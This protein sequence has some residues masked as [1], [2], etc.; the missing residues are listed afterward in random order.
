MLPRHFIFAVIGTALLT[1]AGMAPANAATPAGRAI[2]ADRVASP[3][4]GAITVDAA[5]GK[6]LFED[7]ADEQGYPASVQKVM[8]LVVILDKVSQG[9]LK[10]NESVPIT[11]EASKTGGSQV[12]LD[13]REMFP[14]DELLYALMVQSANDAA[15][16]LATHVAGSKDA[17]IELMN[18]K[19]KAIGM[20][21]T[22]FHSV[23]GLPPSAGHEPDV[24]TARDL[25]LLGRE[26]ILKHPE[27]LKYTSTRKREFREGKFIMQNHDHLLATFTGCDGLKT[28]YFTQAGYSILA[29]ASRNNARVI[30]VV[31]GAA[32]GTNAHHP[33]AA[34]DAKAAELMNKGFA[35]LAAQPAAK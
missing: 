7:H 11:V 23:H 29:T 12:Y 19:A 25:A 22:A 5:T 18:Q 26:L 13:P 2:I 10:L 15:V 28:G 31:L 27:A 35:A 32:K 4:I 14:V 30:T 3:Y 8:T 9:A 1:I 34:R 17:F 6:V 24:T 20:K 21:N 33:N 16:A